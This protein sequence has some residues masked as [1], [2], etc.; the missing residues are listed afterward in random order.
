MFRELTRSKQK[1]RIYPNT[2]AFSFDR[3]KFDTKKLNEYTN[4]E[5]FC[6]KK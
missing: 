6:V 1:F 2:D 5:E 3:K 4:W